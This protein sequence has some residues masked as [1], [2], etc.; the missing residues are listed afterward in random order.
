MHPSQNLNLLYNEENKNLFY[1]CFLIFCLAAFAFSPFF[2]VQAS[3]SRALMAV[4]GLLTL[5][6]CLFRLDLGIGL[7][8]LIAPVIVVGEKAFGDYKLVFATFLMLLWLTKKLY[9]R[10]N[11]SRLINHP[12]AGVI[13]GFTLLGGLSIL[14]APDVTVSVKYMLKYLGNLLFFFVFLDMLRTKQDVRRIGYFLLAG[15][16]LEALYGSFE[17]IT[18]YRS[19]F[20]LLY[21][22]QGTFYHPNIYARFMSVACLFAL[23]LALMTEKKGDR[24]KY[25][26]IGGLLLAGLLV[27]FSRGALLSLS[28]GGLFLISNALRWKYRRAVCAGIAILF[29]LLNS[30]P[31]FSLWHVVHPAE[32]NY[33]AE[34]DDELRIL[35]EGSAAD[36]FISQRLLRPLVRDHIWQGSLKMIL[37]RP[38]TGFGPG[39]IFIASPPF[40]EMT[41]WDLSFL[42]DQYAEEGY[43]FPHA[44]PN[45]HNIFLHIGVELGLGGILL[46]IW[47]YAIIFGRL[48][49]KLSPENITSN[50]LA[51]GSASCVI[52]DLFMGA[53][54]PANMFGP[55][56]LGFLFVFFASLIFIPQEEKSA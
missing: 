55:G 10:E 52:A 11:L 3:F 12:L 29:L 16:C 33:T 26:P 30:G 22:S 23:T 20:P 36:A 14:T 9:Y 39:S 1:R 7:L 28:A 50:Y 35:H 21:R 34:F 17:F 19:V 15:A 54:E 45:G 2:L 41:Y 43:I 44:I 24:L 42:L 32:P 13:L 37:E 53:V 51:L 56:C 4:A 27:S 47:M 25:L 46:M 8:F 5:L 40:L 18:H 31:L 38:W 49:T 6:V 48:K